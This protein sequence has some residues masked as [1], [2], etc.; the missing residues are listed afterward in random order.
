[1]VS[2][3]FL[4]SLST[5]VKKLLS[6]QCKDNEPSVK[7]DIGIID[8]LLQSFDSKLCRTGPSS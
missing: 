1:M 3:G 6:K 7:A 2:R 5:A 8:A 4:Y